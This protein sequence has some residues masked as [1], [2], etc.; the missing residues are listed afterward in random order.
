MRKLTMFVALVGL[1]AVLPSVAP[2]RTPEI[3]RTGGCSNGADWKLKAKAD[4]GRIQVES[5]S[6]RT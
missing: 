2:A 3:I 4:D 6:T 1:A 5:R